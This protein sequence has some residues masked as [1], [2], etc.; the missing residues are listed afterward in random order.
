MWCFYIG[1][2]SSANPSYNALFNFCRFPFFFLFLVNLQRSSKWLFR[3]NLQRAF[4]RKGN[5]SVAGFLDELIG[6][7][8]LFII[9]HYP[10]KFSL[11]LSLHL[12]TEKKINRKRSI[13]RNKNQKIHQ[14]YYEERQKKKK[15]N[16]VLFSINKHLDHE[17]FWKHMTMYA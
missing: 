2:F 17:S 15:N 7:N 6:R 13:A 1:E 16:F 9:T 3:I 12:K 5:P 10:P 8:F 4:D 11:I 14:Y